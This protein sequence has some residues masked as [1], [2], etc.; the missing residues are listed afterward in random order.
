[1]ATVSRYSHLG[2]IYIP[3]FLNVCHSSQLASSSVYVSRSGAMSTG[4][5]C[6]VTRLAEVVDVCCCRQSHSEAQDNPEGRVDTHSPLVSVT[7]VVSTLTT[8]VCEP[9]SILS[10][11]LRPTFTTGGKSYHLHAWRLSC[12]TTGRFL[13]EVSCRSS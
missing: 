6:S 10:V 12:S 11:R 2:R 3:G 7:T 4:D 1:M 5:R 9:P 13:R 8:T